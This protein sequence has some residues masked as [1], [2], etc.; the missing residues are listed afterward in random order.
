MGLSG[1]IYPGNFR[2]FIFAS[3]GLALTLAGCLAKETSVAMLEETASSSGGGT[4]TYPSFDSVNK[5]IIQGRCTVCHASGLHNFANYQALM[6]SGTIVPGNSRASRFYLSTV[7]GSMPTGAYGRLTSNEMIGLAA[8]IDAGA[9]QFAQTAATPTPTPTPTQ[10][11][12]TQPS[13]NTPVLYST[14]ANTIFVPKCVSC[15]S[16][17]GGTAAGFYDMTSYSNVMMRVRAGNAFQ[18]RLYSDTSA[19]RM[20]PAPRTFLT[21][22]EN[23]MIFDW[24]SQGAK[25]DTGAITAAQV[26]AAIPLAATYASVSA[27]VLVKHCISCHGPTVAYAGI[28]V[29]T[30]ANV[31]RGVSPGNAANSAIYNSM[32]AGRMPTA[33]KISAAELDV[34]RTWIQ[35]GAPNN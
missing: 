3:V 24:I 28:K 14:L 5:A 21:A 20:P 27:N 29:D 33:G 22:A 18:S 10:S 26:P 2:P 15:H 7:E 12:G 16:A 6:S 8:W 19:N 25:N 31:V 32:A 13:T 34:L 23:Q 9:P 11:N 35:N 1:K 17:N 4:L 30:Y